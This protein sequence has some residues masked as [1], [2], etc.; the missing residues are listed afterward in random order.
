VPRGKENRAF[1]THDP[2]VSALLRIAVVWNI[3]VARTPA[4]PDSLISSPL[5]S[6]SS[7][8]LEP[9]HRVSV[10]RRVDNGV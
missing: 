9:D 6:E 1:V 3:P 8:R 10:R 7:K 4:T 5:M 2:D